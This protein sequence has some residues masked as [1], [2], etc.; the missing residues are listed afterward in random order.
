[1]RL[2]S[3]YGIVLLCITLGSFGRPVRA[4]MESLPSL[5]QAD[6]TAM[7]IDMLKG[8]KAVVQKHRAGKEVATYKIVSVRLFNCAL[9]YGMLA[10]NPNA[11]ISTKAW[12]SVSVEA[13]RKSATTLYP[14]SN[15][16]FI[17][18]IEASKSEFFDIQRD[19]RKIFY[20]LRNCKDL[21]DPHPEIVLNAVTE[22]TLE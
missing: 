20:L 11:D 9:T 16:E 1:M 5:T 6:R 22:L 19:K 10:K 7:V 21:S 2:V 17:K 8:I 12:F 4:Q 13:Y 3:A 18:D 15:D 14:G